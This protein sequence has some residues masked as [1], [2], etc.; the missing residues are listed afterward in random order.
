MMNIS[1]NEYSSSAYLLFFMKPSSSEADYHE[2]HCPN[3]Q[4]ELSKL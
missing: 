2:P 3:P 4:E 1:M